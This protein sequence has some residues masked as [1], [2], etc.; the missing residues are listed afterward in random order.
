MKNINKG[1]SPTSHKAT[2]GQSLIEVVAAIGIVALVVTGMAALMTTALG[3]KTKGFDRKKAVEMSEIVME[4]IIGVRN[5]SPDLFWNPTSAYWQNILA[6]DLTIVTYPG[7]S[8]RVVL[9]TA[10]AACPGCQEVVLNIGWSGS[11]DK[12]VFTRLFTKY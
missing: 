3:T 5:T 4:Q 8:Y 2:T 7:Y 11:Q 12:V 1:Q 9:N 10:V 6:Q